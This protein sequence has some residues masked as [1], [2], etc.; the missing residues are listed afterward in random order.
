MEFDY[1]KLHGPYKGIND[2]ILK[3]FFTFEKVTLLGLRFLKKNTLNL[4][5]CLF[6][7]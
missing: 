4:T 7:N 3:V 1:V 6:K 5:N 2:I